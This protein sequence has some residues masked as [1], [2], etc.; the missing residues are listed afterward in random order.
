M[1]IFL[2]IHIYTVYLSANSEIWGVD[3][4]IINKLYFL[5]ILYEASMIYIGMRHEDV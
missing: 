3:I 4:L 2:N 1:F 5:S